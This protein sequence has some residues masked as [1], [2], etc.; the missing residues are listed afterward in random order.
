ME[1]VQK[2]SMFVRELRYKATEIKANTISITL[3]F[4][5]SL[6]SFLRFKNVE[7]PRCDCLT[8]LP[9]VIYRSFLDRERERKRI[10]S[11][12]QKR[13]KAQAGMGG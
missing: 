11:S 13:E 4:A 12:S 7:N 10:S 8:A 2:C 1:L 9:A 3:P 6:P 5:H